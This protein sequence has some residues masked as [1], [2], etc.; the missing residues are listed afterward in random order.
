MVGAFA[1]TFGDNGMESFMRKNKIVYVLFALGFLVGL[2]IL[3]YPVISSRWNAY[4]AKQLISTYNGTITEESDP[5]GYQEAMEAAEAYNAQLKQESV[6]DAFSVRDGVQDDAYE[7]ILN[8]NGDG[9]MGS[10]EIPQIGETLPIYH[11]TTEESLEKGVGHLYGSSM[12]VGGESTHAILSAHRGLPSAKLFTDLPLLTEGDQFYIHILGKTLA[13][14]VD[15]TETVEPTDV[16]SLAIVDGEDRVT[17]VTC[18]PYGVNTQRFL[19]HAHRVDFV[20][21]TYEEVQQAGSRTD[22]HQLLMQMLCVLIGLLLA[23]VI[24]IIIMWLDKRRAN[25]T[26]TGRKGNGKE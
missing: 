7:A 21:E 10:I 5:E 25:I 20:E 8:L 9:L 17:L 16:K 14:E 12:P 3:L 1:P 24:V 18:T 6:P 23:F 13:Y 19:V 26:H 2:S 15:G 11:Y 22:S 4:R